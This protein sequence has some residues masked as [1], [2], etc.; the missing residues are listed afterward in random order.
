VG[1][2]VVPLGGEDVAQRDREESRD[3]ERRR[4]ISALFVMEMRMVVIGSGEKANLKRTVCETDL[5]TYSC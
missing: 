5:N 2:G 1:K 4:S 3:D